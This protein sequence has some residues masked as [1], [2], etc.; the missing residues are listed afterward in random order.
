MAWPPKSWYKAL[1]GIIL[2][3]ALIAQCIGSI[4]LFR[5]RVQH[6]ADV[7]YD[8][9]I[10]QLSIGGLCT[11]ILTII[12]VLFEPRSPLVVKRGEAWLQLFRP[13]CLDSRFGPF[14]EGAHLMTLEYGVFNA[15]YFIATGFGLQTGLKMYK[16]LLISWLAPMFQYILLVLIIS[17]RRRTP[18][19][20]YWS[21]SALIVLG[22]CCLLVPMALL[23]YVILLTDVSGASHIRSSSTRTTQRICAQA[24]QDPKADW[25]WWLA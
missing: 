19:S 13:R 6:Q 16:G 4:Y 22:F 21:I 14:Y 2:Q 8:H 18:V 9:R 11:A 20:P 1:R 24:W 25:V 15:T 10:L 5:R 7:P 23:D 12:L 3:L 17:G